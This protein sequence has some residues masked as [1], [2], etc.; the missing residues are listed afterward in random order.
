MGIPDPGTSNGSFAGN[1]TMRL[2]RKGTDSDEREAR[3]FKF[4]LIEDV[5]ISGGRGGG[6]SVVSCR[7][8]TARDTTRKAV[9]GRAIDE[10][11]NECEDQNLEHEVL[12]SEHLD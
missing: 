6:G 8:S 5:N 3:G 7:F 1:K 12:V 10:C 2:L 4:S 9:G 11:R